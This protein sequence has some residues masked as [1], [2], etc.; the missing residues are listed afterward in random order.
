MQRPSNSLDRFRAEPQAT[1]SHIN[2]YP[3]VLPTP[4]PP[5]QGIPRLPPGVSWTFSQTVSEYLP[6]CLCPPLYNI[7]FLTFVF[8]TCV[9]GL[10]HLQALS[11]PSVHLCFLFSLSLLLS[12]MVSGSLCVS[13]SLFLSLLSLPSTYFQL[14]VSLSICL[15]LP[16]SFSLCLCISA[17][18]PSLSLQFSFPSPAHPTPQGSAEEPTLGPTCFP[19]PEQH[20]GQE[21]EAAVPVCPSS[22][23][24]IP[25]QPV[26]GANSH[27]G[28]Y[29]IRLICSPRAG[30]SWRKPQW[31][32]E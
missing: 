2:S 29:L 32:T 31:G 10:H 12:L 15:C 8:S 9:I 28:L 13:L 7:G 18:L 30:Q 20:G 11:F 25:R 6:L 26:P 5:A 23:A 14:C 19:P 21:I 16:I 24:P 1:W 17:S 22:P 3:P 4:V 27:G